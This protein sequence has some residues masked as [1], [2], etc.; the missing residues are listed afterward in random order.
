M[1]D[2]SGCDLSEFFDALEGDWW[3]VFFFGL[4]DSENSSWLDSFKPQ[5]MGNFQVWVPKS[6]SIKLYDVAGCQ[7]TDS[8]LLNG[9]NDLKWQIRKWCHMFIQKPGRIHKVLQSKM[10]V[11][12]TSQLNL[13]V[14]EDWRLDDIH[15]CQVIFVE[16]TTKG[17]Q[18]ILTSPIFFLVF[19]LILPL[20]L[21]ITTPSALQFASAFFFDLR[22]SETPNGP[23]GR[24]GMSFCCLDWKLQRFGTFPALPTTF[25]SFF[26]EWSHRAM[27]TK[28]TNQRIHT[29]IF[30][31][32]WHGGDDTRSYWWNGFFIDWG[33]CL[34]VERSPSISS[35]WMLAW[36]MGEGLRYT[37]PL[38]LNA[39]RE[40]WCHTWLY[41]IY[42]DTLMIHN[43][44]RNMRLLFATIIW[45][46]C[47]WCMEIACDY[48]PTQEAW[49]DFGAE[50]FCLHV[51]SCWTC[52]EIPGI[53][54][55]SV[56]SKKS[57][58]STKETGRIFLRGEPPFRETCDMC[59]DNM[60]GW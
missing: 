58:S 44:V 38:K 49:H 42:N 22:L 57:I 31:G 28:W 37:K 52:H 25:L 2:F 19:L 6:W 23:N 41:F 17:F 54:S 15:H 21:R 45:F 32:W 20:P 56:H 55:W 1:G 47:A 36:E 16:S 3:K 27:V 11:Q 39:T 14:F 30:Y 10:T 40:R 8:G 18:V 13:E 59:L 51:G 48:N 24:H 34:S 9:L 29:C 4:F 35:S 26:E 5:F 12:V 7:V 60:N 50:P 46:Q 53:Q 33:Q 43:W